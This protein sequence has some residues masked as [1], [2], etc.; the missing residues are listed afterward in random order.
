[1]GIG[2]VSSHGGPIWA[3]MEIVGTRVS[4]LDGHNDRTG[5]KG[6]GR[7]VDVSSD[8]GD[9]VGTDQE[10]FRAWVGGTILVGT[11]G[12]IKVSSDGRAVGAIGQFLGAAV[13]RTG[14]ERAVAL[15]RVATDVGAVGARSP[16]AGA[17]ITAETVRVG[18]GSS[19][20]CD[21]YCHC[22]KKQK[23]DGAENVFHHDDPHYCF[24]C[25]RK[26]KV[27]RPT[28]PRPLAI[29]ADRRSEIRTSSPWARDGRPTSM[30]H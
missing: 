9:A 27:M 22:D 3:G 2:I 5:F 10:I 30:T 20:L 21:R 14:L 26:E 23:K 6:T 24:C 7:L 17:P 4:I 18:G 28:T 8:R 13:T 15:R 16:I 12:M 1:M 25:K 11:I 29:S 19:T